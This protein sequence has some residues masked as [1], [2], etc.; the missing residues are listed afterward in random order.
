MKVP[1]RKITSY[2]G[3]SYVPASREVWAI[4]HNR[5]SGV[6]SIDVNNDSDYDFSITLKNDKH[7]YS[8]RALRRSLT[9][10]SATAATQLS[11]ATQIAAAINADGVLQDAVT[12]VVVGDGTGAYGLTGATDYGVEITA[13]LLTQNQTT[14]HEERVYWNLNLEDFTSGFDT[15]TVGRI[16]QMTYGKGTYAQVSLAEKKAISYEGVLN[17]TKWPI[18]T[19]IYAGS[20]T[21][22]TSANVSA[23]TGNVSITSGEDVA[24]VTANGIIRP[25][26]I[27]DI[28]GTQYEVKYLIG[29]TQFV[30][31]SLATA[32]YSGA[33][34]KVKY[35]YDSIVIEFS[36][37]N[38]LEAAGVTQDNRQSVV[39]C[40]PAIASGG[41]YNI[42]SAQGI[43]LLAVLNPYMASLGFANVTL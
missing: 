27:I 16:E 15:T 4:G 14:Y 41:A 35:G 5:Q 7:L 22:V 8:E 30:I 12:A 28:D 38:L 25:G 34:L 18:P 10:R 23:T 6:G 40:T 24:T 9:F 20:S 2:L 11:I 37:P 39:I 31:T 33:N 26:E 3:Q 29:T 42:S 17:F 36:N 13:K 21:L 43:D 19:Q 32:T 1:G